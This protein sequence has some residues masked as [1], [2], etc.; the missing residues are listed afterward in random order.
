MSIKRRKNLIKKVFEV[1]YKSFI[2]GY[3]KLVNDKED[4]AL[5][6]TN[7]FY[8]IFTSDKVSQIIETVPGWSH[9]VTNVSDEELICMLW[10]N[11][12]FDPSKP[13]TFTSIVG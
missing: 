11:E 9:D 7:E 5:D 12:V 1:E 13:D 6:I 10:A 4:P 2:T 8:E 3:N